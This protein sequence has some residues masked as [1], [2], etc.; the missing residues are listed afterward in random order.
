[1]YILL[2]LEFPKKT[3]THF[4]PTKKLLIGLNQIL[5]NKIHKLNKS[6]PLIK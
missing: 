5:Q 6:R 4:D 3:N 2:T 1:M